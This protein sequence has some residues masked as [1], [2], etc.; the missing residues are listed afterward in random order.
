MQASE[1][2]LCIFCESQP[3]LCCN[4]SQAGNT[5]CKYSPEDQRSLIHSALSLVTYQYTGIIKKHFSTLVCQY[6]FN[7]IH[8]VHP[9]NNCPFV[10]KRDIYIFAH[11]FR[12]FYA[13][14]SLLLPCN[15]YF[16][17][18]IEGS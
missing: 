1:I 2:D 11:G 7:L 9:F 5:S 3:G 14:Y 8:H 17:T 12:S 6:F 13:Y 10:Y 4:T 18:S 15:N 16:T